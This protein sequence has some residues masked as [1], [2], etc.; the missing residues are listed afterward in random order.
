MSDPAAARP[1]APGAEAPELDRERAH[2]RA[3]TAGV[4]LARGPARGGG[5]G[6]RGG[7]RDAES[8]A[9]GRWTMGRPPYPRPGWSRWGGPPYPRPGRF[10]EAR[11]PPTTRPRRPRGRPPRP[12]RRRSGGAPRS[13]TR[14]PTDARPCRRKARMA[15]R[16]LLPQ[17]R[18]PDPKPRP[19]AGGP[20]GGGH[21]A[22]RSPES[23]AG[24][25]GK[26]DV[27]LPDVDYRARAV[28]P[29][30]G[31]APAATGEAA[32]GTRAPVRV[33]CSRRR[34]CARRGGPSPPQGRVGG[35]RVRVG[36]P[37]PCPRARRASPRP[38]S[39][40]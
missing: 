33:R 31:S 27:A 5:D 3:A 26:L 9:A 40:W 17:H 8:A 1:S 4:G 29:G 25:A 24:A 2:R 22:D 32:A 16:G 11:P 7:L 39:G 6:G 13:A 37:A 30:R 36:A 34:D 23:R 20:H 12:T 38:I 21:G 35:A 28:G 15:A 14:R 19:P 10:G 18:P